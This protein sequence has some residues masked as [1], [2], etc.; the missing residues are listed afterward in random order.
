M[1]EATLMK[2]FKYACRNRS[3]TNVTSRNVV[4]TLDD[5]LAANLNKRD[6]LGITRFETDRCSCWNVETI[7]VRSNTIEF[8]LWVCFDEV[9]V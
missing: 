2:F 3:I 6:S 9:V 1:Q 5:L 4:A 8:K 7:A